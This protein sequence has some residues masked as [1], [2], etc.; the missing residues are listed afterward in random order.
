MLSTYVSPFSIASGLTHVHVT[1]CHPP[2][3]AGILALPTRGKRGAKQDLAFVS[4][5][6]SSESET[7]T[8]NLKH[9][10]AQ[11]CLPPVERDM[12]G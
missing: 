2:P 1:L 5:P 10:N 9:L 7:T 12:T 8:R 4:V 11:R 3:P 6:S